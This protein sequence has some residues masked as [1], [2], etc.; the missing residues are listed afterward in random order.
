MPSLSPPPEMVL[1]DVVV[2]AAVAALAGARPVRPVWRN[3]LGGLTFEL[4]DSP[5]SFVKFAPKGTNLPL[6]RE[7]ERLA[8][9]ARYTPVPQVLATGSDKS[10]IWLQTAALTGVSAVHPDFLKNPGKA[11]TAIAE[12]LR[13]LHDRLPVADCPY[14][15]SVEDRLRNNTLDLSGAHPIHRELPADEAI[16]RAND[17]PP[18]DRLV[19]CHGDSCAPNTLIGPDGRWSGHVDLADL[20]VADRWADLAVASWSLS[21]NY[22]DG[23]EDRFFAAYGID[24]DPARIA[25][26]RLLWDLG[27]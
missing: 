7:T 1:D 5:R 26:Y 11:V 17:P 10:G 2:P 23:W 6:A 13:A 16:K 18:I 12:G 14:T 9:A 22:G 19:V 8:W 21:W 20:G 15:W 25:Y 3:V 24:P 4:T 27:G